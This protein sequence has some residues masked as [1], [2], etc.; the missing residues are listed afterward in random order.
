MRRI[1]II[2][3]IFF[4]SGTVA[5]ETPREIKE[6]KNIERLGNFITRWYFDLVGT[7]LVWKETLT[8]YSDSTFHYVFRGGECATID[9]DTR[10]TWNISNDTLRLTSHHDFFN[11]TYIIANGKLYPP[12]LDIKK[13]PKGWAMK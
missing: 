1:L 12:E 7:S 3:M 13:N 5:Q 8:L 11:H 9:E 2:L 4:S 6:Y 10:G